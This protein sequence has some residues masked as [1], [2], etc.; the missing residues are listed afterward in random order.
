MVSAGG[1]S[2]L[3]DNGNENV[4]E[5]LIPLAAFFVLVLFFVKQSDGDIRRSDVRRQMSAR[6]FMSSYLTHAEKVKCILSRASHL[7][8]Q[9]AFSRNATKVQQEY[10]WHLISRFSKLA[11]LCFPWY[12]PL[13]ASGRPGFFK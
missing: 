12:N 8:Q 7:Y 1:I 9:N 10:G 13:T 2:V 5:D 3:I 4:A 6:L 11:R